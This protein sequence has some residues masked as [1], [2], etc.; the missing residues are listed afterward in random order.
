MT[1]AWVGGTRARQAAAGP[2][3][4]PHT[5]QKNQKTCP[6]TRLAASH[7]QDAG[8]RQRPQQAGGLARVHHQQQLAVAPLLV[9][10]RRRAGVWGAQPQGQGGGLESASAPTAAA[11]D[12]SQGQ[13]GGLGKCVRPHSCSARCVAA[14][15]CAK[16][17]AWRARG[18]SLGVN[19]SATGVQNACQMNKS[20]HGCTRARACASASARSCPI[21]SSAP[22]NLR[23]PSPPWP[24]RYT[25]QPGLEHSFSN[26][27]APQCPPPRAQ[28]GVTKI[29]SKGFGLTSTFEPLS[30]SRRWEAG[31]AGS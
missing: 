3:S 21:I 15:A 26:I 16:G 2:P 25:C 30:D 20:E 19:G 24:D 28:A 1:A 29:E 10:L 17:G 8:R 12:G 18:S 6:L 4:P 31:T 13:E 14:R 22:W 7:G 5:H 11:R 27:S 9:H 23:K